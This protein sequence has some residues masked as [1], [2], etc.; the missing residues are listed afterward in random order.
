MICYQIVCE[1]RDAYA[2]G[3][4]VARILPLYSDKSGGSSDYTLT[5][6]FLLVG[7]EKDTPLSKD[8]LHCMSAS[9]HGIRLAAEIVD[10]PCSH[11]NTDDFVKVRGNKCYYDD[12]L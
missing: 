12:S 11:M 6:E 2:L 4:A 5:V 8:D 9:A 7:A 1:R 10:K 3:C